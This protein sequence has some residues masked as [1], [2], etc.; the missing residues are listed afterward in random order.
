L[1]WVKTWDEQEP[2]PKARVKQFPADKAYLRL[3]ARELQAGGILWIPKSRQ[4]LLSWINAAH[5]VWR[6]LQP[7][8]HI[9]L[10]TQKED[11]AAWMIRDRCYF[12]FQYLPE[13]LKHV[14]LKGNTEATHIFCKMELPNR[15]KI[16][17][18]P[19]GADQLRGFTPSVFFGD[20]V[21]YQPKFED[22][23]T[24][25]LPLSQRGIP[26][27]FVSTA[28]GGTYMGEVVNGPIAGQIHQP[29]P[30][31]RKWNLQSGGRVLE[32][33]YSSDPAK[34]DAWKTTEI[35]KYPGGERGAKWQQEQE[36]QWDAYSG[37]LVYGGWNKHAHVVQ[38]FDLS[39][40]PGPYWRAADYGI[41]NP[42][43]VGWFTQIDDV[44][45]LIREFYESGMTVENMKRA[46]HAMSTEKTYAATWIDPRSDRH[47]QIGEGS[48]F[49][50]LNAG[51]YSL[52]AIKANSSGTGIE[53]INQ[54][55]HDGRF[56][57]FSTCTNFIREIENYRY[58]DWG[59]AVDDKHNLK[60]KTVKRD[61]HLMDAT[62]YFAN[63]VQHREHRKESAVVIPIDNEYAKRRERLMHPHRGQYTGRTAVMRGFYG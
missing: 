56:K 11:K 39:G 58:E 6:A 37:S 63:G 29:L 13:W 8:S 26:M 49:F 20:E 32:V 10:Q 55:L 34:D 22:A 27:I 1:R 57:V 59:T 17:G 2:D 50:N 42:F 44:Y 19:E 21:S 5:L 3:V 54:W 15:S 16:E 14:A 30:G 28:A 43:A 45:Y 41:R 24:A 52:R 38:P 62:K 53:L 47:E 18:V 36:I 31:I 25:L 12:I 40:H 7:N 61:D 46:V 23:H 51:E 33:H 60:E 4:L 35:Q 48:A 9:F